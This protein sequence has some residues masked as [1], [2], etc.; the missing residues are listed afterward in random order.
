YEKP[1][2]VKFSYKNLPNICLVTK[3]SM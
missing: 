3:I 1:S 2:K